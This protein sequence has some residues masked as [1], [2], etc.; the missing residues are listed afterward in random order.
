[1]PERRVYMYSVFMRAN[2]NNT[3]EERESF[4]ASFFVGGGERSFFFL[5]GFCHAWREQKIYESFFIC[6]KEVTV[7]QKGM[8]TFRQPLFPRQTHRRIEEIAFCVFGF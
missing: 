3:N 1:M 7:T 5:D 6:K 2:I 8:A 4:D